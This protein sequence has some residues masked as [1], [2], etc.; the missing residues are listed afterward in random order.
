MTGRCS[1]CS[2]TAIRRKIACLQAGMSLMLCTAC[3]YDHTDRH[4]AEG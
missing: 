2:V 1:S 3:Y 4:G